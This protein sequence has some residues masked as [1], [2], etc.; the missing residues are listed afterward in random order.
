MNLI[1]G[2][3]AVL[4]LAVVN[5][6]VLGLVFLL[7]LNCRKNAKVTRSIPEFTLPIMWRSGITS[8]DRPTAFK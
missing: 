4:A 7:I 3:L 8:G 5:G 6:L 2:C 1:L